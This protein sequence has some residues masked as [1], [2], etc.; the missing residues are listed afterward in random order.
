[1]YKSKYVSDSGKIFYFDYEHEVLA[2]IDG[3]TGM[4]INLGLSQGFNQIGQTVESYTVSGREISINGK[5]LNDATSNKHNIIDVF[6]PQTKGKLYFEDRYF[7]ECYVK[8]APIIGVQKRDARFSLSLFA[9]YPYWRKS[10]ANVIVIGEYT[11]SFSFPVI[12][13]NHIFGTREN[14]NFVNCYNSGNL[15]SYFKIEIMS[16]KKIFNPKI[17]NETTHEYIKINDSISP[18]EIYKIYRVS[19]RLYV[20]KTVK[21]LTT[22]EFSMLDEDSNFMKLKVGDNVVRM[23]ADADTNFMVVTISYNDSVVGVYEGI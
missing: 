2:D 10:V 14:L 21:G 6:A 12:Y 23:E 16:K 17:V 22:N 19:N 18:G 11:P 9:E 7:L 20:E 15:D 5:F 3:L 4:N 1:M 13:D 8:S